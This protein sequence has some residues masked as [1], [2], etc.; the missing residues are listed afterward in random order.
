MDLFT[1]MIELALIFWAVIYTTQI[2]ISIKSTIIYT[3]FIVIPTTLIYELGG[4]WQGIIYLIISSFIYFFWL[5]KDLLIFIHICF[6]LII[7]ILTDNFTQYIAVATHI[8][9]LPHVFIHYCIFFVLFIASILIYRIL[10][11]NIYTLIGELKTAYMLILSVALVTMSTFYINI[12]LT[13]YLSRN[14]ILTFNIITQIIYFTMMIAV[15]YITIINIRKEAHFRKIE[16]ETKQFTSY[17][18]SLELINN[19][20][21]KFQHDYTNILVTMQGYI[22]ADEFEELKRYFKKYILTAGEET[23]K[24][25]KRFVNLSK[26]QITGLKGLIITKSL[27]AEKE[28]ISFNVEISDEI[29]EISINIIDLARIVGI[30]LDNAI[31]ANKQNDMQ[32]EKEVNIA[33]FN[34]MSGSTIII[35]ENTFDNSSITINQIFTDGFSTKGK[36]RGKGLNIVKNIIDNYPNLTLN[37]SIEKHLFTQIIEIKK[38]EGF[39]EGR[40]M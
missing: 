20:M 9:F 17:M 5:S 29:N 2:K 19:D 39:H 36:K 10:T 1:L 15:L 13:N 27:Q 32:E 8:A 6:V 35:I 16:I 18:H 21:Q 31:E 38:N 26:L 28:G 37:T 24:R 11:R 23:L 25:N 4:N 34:S 3:V 33:F 22:E 30:F 14:S 40:N 12:Y 7:G